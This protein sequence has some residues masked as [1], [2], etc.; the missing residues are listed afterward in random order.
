MKKWLL[1]LPTILRLYTSV[2]PRNPEKWTHKGSWSTDLS[3]TTIFTPGCSPRVPGYMYW[4][5][6]RG[7][8]GVVG[9]WVGWRGYTGTHQYPVPGPILVIF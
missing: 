4:G 8:P 2:I 7:V 3:P 9:Y 6:W 1:I 5:G